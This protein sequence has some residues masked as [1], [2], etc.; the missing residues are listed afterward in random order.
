MARIVRVVDDLEVTAQGPRI[1]DSQCIGLDGVNGRSGRSTLGDD[2]GLQGFK[3]SA[4]TV[5][6]IETTITVKHVDQQIVTE[7]IC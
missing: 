6:G 7:F 3:N 5:V 1:R 4:L 2:L